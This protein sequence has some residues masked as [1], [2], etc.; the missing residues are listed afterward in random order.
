MR[1]CRALVAWPKRGDDTW[2]M[3][4]VRFVWLNKLKASKLISIFLNPLTSPSSFNGPLKKVNSL[5]M[6]ICLHEARTLA[7][8][9][10]N[11]RRTVVRDSVTIVIRTGR[12]IERRS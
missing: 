5:L 2:P 10:C 9:A 4:L 6:Q 3:M 11:S 1:A 7:G 12:D 8:I